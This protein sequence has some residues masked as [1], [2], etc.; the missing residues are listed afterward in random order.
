MTLSTE[1]TDSIELMYESGWT[2]GLPVVPPTKDRVAEFITASGRSGEELIAQLPPLGGKA[3]V[4]KIAVNAVMA[5]CLPEYMP[6][7]I[8]AIQALMD[9]RFNLRGVMCSTGI[10]TP[11]MIISGPIVKELNIN[12]SYGCFGH[13]WR[14]N[15]TI[16]RAVKLILV[17][18]GGAVPGDANK[19]TFGHPGSYTYCIGESEENNPWEP[20][21]VEK[22][23]NAEDSTVTV[24]PGEAPHNI[25]Y[26][27]VHPR[28][29]LTVLA[30]TMCPLGNV[31]MYVMGDTFV[32]LGPEHAK[33]LA[34]AGWRKNDVRQFLHENARR[35]VGLLRRGGPAQGDD[36]REIMWPKF[37]D[38]N[39]NDDLV[40]V[41]RRV[42]D[43]HIFVAG[44]PGGPHSV[45][46]PGWGSRSAIRK[47]ERP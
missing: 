28:N 33:L 1:I 26:H 31:Q 19:A 5:G 15:S 47:I 45:Y 12:S 25:M 42:D 35:P 27:A 18:L 29:F 10:H 9:D 3:T 36:R 11:L 44:G 41:V 39:D 22:G 40:P 20:Y 8:T 32:V 30:D 4:E 46:I 43:I 16:G 13:G 7:I 23:F 24:F 2:D 17:N 38:P 6:V 34:E 21:H 14:A 37:V